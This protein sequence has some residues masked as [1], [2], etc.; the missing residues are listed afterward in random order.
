MGNSP[1]GEMPDIEKCMTAISEALSE[2]LP[3]ATARIMTTEGRQTD[4]AATEPGAKNAADTYRQAAVPSSSPSSTGDSKPV[5]FRY[6]YKPNRAG[7]KYGA[8]RYTDTFADVN[9]SGSYEFEPLYA[10]PSATAAHDELLAIHH[11][12][13]NPMEVVYDPKEPW[14]VRTAK[15]FIQRAVGT[16][17]FSQP[18]ASLDQVAA[19]RKQAFLDAAA[20]CVSATDAATMRRMAHE[21]PM[22]VADGRTA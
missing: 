1:D 20:L 22:A 6:R 12:L 17:P 18:T 16:G 3:S 14:T 7:E 21:K 2:A 13:L 5:A 8:W 15:E 11:A 19:I 4:W 10:H 9:Q